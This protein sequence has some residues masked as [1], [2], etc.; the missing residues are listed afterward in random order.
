MSPAPPTNDKADPP[1]PLVSSW[2]ARADAGEAVAVVRVRNL[3]SSIPIGRDAW[4]RSGKLQPVLLSSEVS[5]AVPFAVSESSSANTDKLDSGTV[6]YGNL[7]KALLGSLELLG[8][9]NAADPDSKAGTAASAVAATGY[10]A[11]VATPR[12][13]DVMELL[14]VRMTGRVVDGSRVALPLDQLPFLHAARLRSLSLTVELP[15]ASLLGAGV[16]LTT[17]ASFREDLPKE[18]EKE[19]GDTNQ[20]PLQSYS[21]TLRIHGLHIPTLIG[22]NPNERKA[23]QMLV[24]DVEIDKFDVAEDIHTELEAIVVEAIESSS[25]ETLEALA[26]HVGNKILSDFRIADDPKPMKDRGWRVKVC[27]E[28]PIAIPTAEFPAVEVT[29]G[30]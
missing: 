22:V 13:A 8:Q 21:R 11:E 17:T 7:S 10:E 27:L 23:K 24:V 2:R 20:N 16:S 1:A 19:K 6:H 25:F 30:S 3:R 9:G 5:F 14:W 4:G 26:S 15:K 28:K 29:M 12:T 18:Q